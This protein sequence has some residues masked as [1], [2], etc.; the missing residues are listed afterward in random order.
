V[1]GNVGTETPDDG[2]MV[3]D[4]LARRSGALEGAYR[5]FGAALYSTA[6]N[7]MGNDDDAQ[8]CVHDA[9]L[10]VWQQTTSYRPERGAYAMKHLV[11]SATPRVIFASNSRPLPPTVGIMR[12]R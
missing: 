7:V 10:R 12:S 4:F 11:A 2:R 3:A 5:S 9:L 1:H 8:D 6:R